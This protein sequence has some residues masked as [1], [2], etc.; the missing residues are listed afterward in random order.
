MLSPFDKFLIISSIL[1]ICIAIAIV[2]CF[3][4]ANKIYDRR[5]EESRRFCIQLEKI[6]AERKP[7]YSEEII[8]IE[9]S[10]QVRILRKE[11]NFALDSLEILIAQENVNITLKDNYQ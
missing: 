1:S 10:E 8:P 9:I 6:R 3:L 5:I 2:I 4:I 11:L 7:S